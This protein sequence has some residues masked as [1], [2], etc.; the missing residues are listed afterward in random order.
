M[1]I[2]IEELKQINKMGWWDKFFYTLGAFLFFAVALI[3][4]IPRPWI[5][6]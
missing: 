4:L 6:K 1:L 3:V 5:R 2:P